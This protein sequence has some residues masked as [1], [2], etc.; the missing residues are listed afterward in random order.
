[1]ITQ[2]FFPKMQPEA[3][4]FF[5]VHEL[6]QNHC[7]DKRE[8]TLFPWLHVYYT[9]L[10][11]VRYLSTL[12]VV[13]ANYEFVYIYILYI[14]IYYVCYIIYIYNMYVILYILYLLYIVYILHL[15]YVLHT[16][17][18]S[19]YRERYIFSKIF[20]EALDQ[21]TLHCLSEK[22]YYSIVCIASVR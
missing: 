17:Y 21:N 14:Y 16:Q 5:Q 18:I 12:C 6:L 22:G 3:N 20:S 13:E 2:P 7:C 1:M 19:I 10:A 15:L 4:L 8:C 9:H 11:S